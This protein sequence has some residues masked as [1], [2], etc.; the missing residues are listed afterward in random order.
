MDEHQTRT[1]AEY[2]NHEYWPS[3]YIEWVITERGF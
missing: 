3:E 2:Y 1:V